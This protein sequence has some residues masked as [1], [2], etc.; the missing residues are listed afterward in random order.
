MS[1][2][3][4]AQTT[5]PATDALTELV[6]SCRMRAIGARTLGNHDRSTALLAIANTL[7]AARTRLVE[8]GPEYLDAAWAFV[9]AGRKQIAAL[10]GSGSLLALVRT[11][12]TV[13][14]RRA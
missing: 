10:Y 11:E 1:T 7:D 5:K 8:D 14:R 13:S 6:D 2:M 12:N 3:T 9:D 4:P